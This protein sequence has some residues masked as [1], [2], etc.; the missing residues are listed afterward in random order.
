M[1]L[2]DDFVA[3]G[4]PDCVYN[5]YVVAFTLL[6][7]CVCVCVSSGTD[8]T[9]TLTLVRGHSGSAEETKSALSYIDN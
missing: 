4:C 6:C 5:Y 8:L 3:I 2:Y 1:I 7:A 9:M